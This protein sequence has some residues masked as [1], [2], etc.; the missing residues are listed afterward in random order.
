MSTSRTF[1]AGP[2]GRVQFHRA[3]GSEVVVTGD[4]YTTDDVHEIAFLESHPAVEESKRPASSKATKEED[5]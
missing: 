1:T 4:G 2:S 5:S 3:D